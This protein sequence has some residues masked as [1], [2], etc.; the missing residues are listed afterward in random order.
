MIFFQIMIVDYLPNSPHMTVM[1]LFMF[2]SSVTIIGMMIFYVI[3]W[4]LNDYVLSVEARIRND[5]I[6]K[7][8][9]RMQA[10]AIKLQR[11][12]RRHRIHK[13]VSS[14]KQNLGGQPATLSSACSPRLR[15]SSLAKSRAKQGGSSPFSPVVIA[16]PQRGWSAG[17]GPTKPR[18]PSTSK[19]KATSSALS[20]DVMMTSTQD[21]PTIEGCAGSSSADPEASSRASVAQTTVRLAA[22]GCGRPHAR[23]E[24]A[25]AHNALD[26]TWLGL[27]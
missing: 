27:T 1:H 24:G 23:S 2:L 22:S 14:G 3:I 4:A 16:Q 5:K 15:W 18:S 13:V 7:R 17:G 12:F 25:A 6:M 8:S 20:G 10:A 19:G 11:A 26:L 9:R 21:D